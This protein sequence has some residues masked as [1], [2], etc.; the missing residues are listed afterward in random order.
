MCNWKLSEWYSLCTISTVSF[1]CCL[2]VLQVW[3]VIEFFLSPVLSDLLNPSSLTSLLEPE[4]MFYNYF[5]NFRMT[6]N[7]SDTPV[8]NLDGSA[9][10]WCVFCTLLGELCSLTKVI[11]LSFDTIV[12]FSRF[13]LLH[14]ETLY[15]SQEDRTNSRYWASDSNNC[16]RFLRDF[17]I[18]CC[19]VPGASGLLTGFITYIF[20]PINIA[21]KYKLPILW[22]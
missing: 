14:I 11:F 10:F 3:Y 17:V 13:L 4:C 8:L 1:L 9:M 19:I 15:C 6:R 20:A 16:L 5:V 7:F 12:C 2:S 18:F 21:A 22:D